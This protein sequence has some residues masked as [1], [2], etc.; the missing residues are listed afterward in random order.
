MKNGQIKDN[1][2]NTIAASRD[3]RMLYDAGWRIVD[4]KRRGMFKQVWWYNPADTE[5]EVM[6]QAQAVLIEKQLS[7]KEV[8][9]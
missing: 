5:P 3:M 8:N 9:R 4:I 2:G 7:N 1:K 6:T